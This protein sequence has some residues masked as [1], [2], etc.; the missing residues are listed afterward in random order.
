MCKVITPEGEGGHVHTHTHDPLEI[1]EL[2]R[3]ALSEELQAMNDTVARW[4]MIEEEKEKKVF[5]QIA[6]HR[7]RIIEEL[8][9]ALATLEEELFQN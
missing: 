9:K 3:E 8:S 4:H 6:R 7:Q 2:M 5:L 1:A